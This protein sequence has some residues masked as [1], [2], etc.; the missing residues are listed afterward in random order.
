MPLREI[1]SMG[2]CPVCGYEMLEREDT[3]PWGKDGDS[4]SYGI[5]PSCGIEFGYQ[6][7]TVE[8]LRN[9]DDMH[10]RLDIYRKW[11]NDWIKNGMKY[12]HFDDEF[13]QPLNWDPIRQLK[14]IGIRIDKSGKI[15]DE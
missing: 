14:N 7:L 15:K 8:I 1:Y 6:D 10:K 13:P 5:C 9:G 12:K 4:Q 11:R 3:F 2:Y